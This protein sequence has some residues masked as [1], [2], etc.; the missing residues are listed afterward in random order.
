[1][2]HSETVTVTRPKDAGPDMLDQPEQQEDI[3]VEVEG[4]DDAAAAAT[5]ELPREVS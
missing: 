1:M 2:R 3:D 5:D 4:D